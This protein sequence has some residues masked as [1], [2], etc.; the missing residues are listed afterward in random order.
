MWVY[1]ILNI[2][3]FIVL[4]F[5][6][7]LPILTL[8]LPLNYH[9]S[10]LVIIMACKQ[11]IPMINNGRLCTACR[12][13]W[14]TERAQQQNLMAQNVSRELSSRELNYYIILFCIYKLCF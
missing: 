12:P 6:S 11:S 8:F 10:L 13:K 7:Y 14:S 3:V 2:T 9:F 5:N 4:N 1:F